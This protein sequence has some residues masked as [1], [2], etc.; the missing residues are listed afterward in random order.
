M[1]D[2]FWFSYSLSDFLMFG[3]EVF[4]RL[5]V[6][7]NQDFWPWQGGAVAMMVLVA[8][9]LVRGDKPA[10]RAVLLLLAAAWIWSG[11]GFLMEYYG[12]IN[13]PA[14]W[15]GWAFILQAALLT[16]AALVWP[17]DGSPEKPARQWH[18]GTA[19]LAMTALLSLL[20]VAQSGNWQ[21]IALFGIAPDVTIAASVPCLLLLPRRVRWLFLLLPL[22]WSVFSAA[23]LWTLGT[24]L[25][26][27]LPL[28]TLVLTVMS[29]WFSPRPVQNRD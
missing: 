21:A 24:R 6:R 17:W 7:I 13:I 26:F 9:L 10:K 29:F 5:F 20:A 3:P 1:T 18:A 12:P 27:V 25:M 22:L 4:L 28:F 8:G 16:V 11:A 2:V 14:T 19:W 15:F 23:T